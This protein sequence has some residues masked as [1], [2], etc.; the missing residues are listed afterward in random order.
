MGEFF[1]MELTPRHPVPNT[2]APTSANRAASRRSSLAIQD[3]GLAVVD[4][5]EDDERLEVGVVDHGE[6]ALLR[7]RLRSRIA[8]GDET[9]HA[10]PLRLA[11]LV[12][13]DGLVEVE[14]ERR[15]DVRV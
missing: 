7:G 8:P 14:V 3:G 15:G 2:V 10:V 12:A 5:R 6:P 11:H 4:D 1:G 13:E 9:E